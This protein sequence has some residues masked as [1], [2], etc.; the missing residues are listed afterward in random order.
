MTMTGRQHSLRSTEGSWV[1][2]LGA[3]GLNT[4]VSER[5]ADADLADDFKFTNLRDGWIRDAIR[6]RMP[7]QD[8]AAHADLRSLA[9][10]AKHERRENLL[11]D[12]I[13]GRLASDAL[14]HPLLVERIP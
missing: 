4:V 8:I 12:N 6:A 2:P 5:T 11:R 1:D 14:G 13:A 7:S 3:C 10:V 9:G